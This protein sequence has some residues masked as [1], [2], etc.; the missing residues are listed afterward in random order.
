MVGSVGSSS[1]LVNM[2]ST[3][4]QQT[5][6]TTDTQSAQTFRAPPPPVDATGPPEDPLGVFDTVDSDSDGS[7]SQDEY[8]ALSQGIM[9]VTGSDL[10]GSFDDFDTDGDGV[11]NGGELR[12][13]M[14]EAG[15]APPPPPPQQVAS[16]YENQ[17]G[18]ISDGTASSED[19][20]SRLLE[21]LETGS[22]DLDTTA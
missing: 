12:S 9:E 17:S 10:S 14:E 19:L 4:Y 22:G 3:I 18:E 16:A 6:T 7:I 2:I 11:L 5:S 15:F 1:N 13:V 20:L 8:D 21:Y